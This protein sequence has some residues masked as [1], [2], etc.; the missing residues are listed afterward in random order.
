VAA[1]TK[2]EE[3]VHS[4]AVQLAIATSRVGKGLLRLVARCGEELSDFWA[5]AQD[6]RRG[7]KS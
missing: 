3:M 6:I 1:T 7:N 5:E 4:V 2:A